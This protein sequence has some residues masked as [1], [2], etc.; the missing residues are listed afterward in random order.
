MEEGINLIYL[1]EMKQLFMK[2]EELI[3]DE[4]CTIKSALILTRVEY[5]SLLRLSPFL[6]LH[7]PLN[8]K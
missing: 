3:K 6:S 7:P 8:E 4:R 2:N 5:Y 1:T